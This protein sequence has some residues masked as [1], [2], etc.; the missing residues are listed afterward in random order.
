MLLYI[1]EYIDPKNSQ[2]SGLRGLY[3][4]KEQALRY[5]QNHFIGIDSANISRDHDDGV[6]QTIRV[7]GKSGF[8]RVRF[9]VARTDV[10]QACYEE[11]CHIFDRNDIENELLEAEEFE[12]DYGIPLSQ[13]SDS[14]KEAMAYRK[15]HLEEK[16]SMSWDD[17]SRQAIKEICDEIKAGVQK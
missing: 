9:I 14:A 4:T 5:A 1:V 13:L 7:K 15:A 17:A 12:D 2:E 6:C 3:P 11:Q 10:V 16:Y 8:W